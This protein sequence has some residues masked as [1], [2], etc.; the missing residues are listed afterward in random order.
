MYYYNKFFEKLNSSDLKDI[1][2]TPY[3]GKGKKESVV[4]LIAWGTHSLQDRFRYDGVVQLY[5]SF[6]NLNEYL[7]TYIVNIDR[8]GQEWRKVKALNKMHARLLCGVNNK[9]KVIEY[10]E[11]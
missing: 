10:K 11:G 3:I 1:F 6:Y 8:Y 4:D 5:G 9:L 2:I 7:K